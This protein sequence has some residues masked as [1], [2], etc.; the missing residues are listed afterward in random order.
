MESKLSGLARV[1]ADARVSVEE[2]REKMTGLIASAEAIQEG[3]DKDQ[4]ALTEDED[5]QVAAF[6]AAYEATKAD[7]ERRQRIAAMKDDLNAPQPRKSQT[8]PLEVSASASATP[9]ATTATRSPITGH[10]VA[11]KHPNYGFANFGKFA[12]AVRVRGLNGPEDPLLRPLGAA[13][14]W[15]SEGLGSDGGYLVPPEFS[16]NIMEKV[17]GEDSLL[18]LTDQMTTASN[19][20]TFP[21]DEVP[22]HDAVNGV[23]IAWEGEGTSYLQTKPAMRSV[24]VKLGKLAAIV[25]AS[26]EL[27]EDASSLGAYLQ[28]KIASKIVWTLNNVLVNGNGVNKPLGLLSA[29]ALVTQA[30]EGS[31]TAG[32]IN[33][34]NILKMWSRCYGPSRKRAVWI[35]NQDAEV[36][37][38]QLL[39]SGGSAVSFPAYLPN[40]MGVVGNPFSSGTLMGRPI[41]FTE[42][43]QAI[44]T[45]GDLILADMT[46]YITLSKGSG[47]QTVQSMHFFFDQGLMAYRTSYRIGGA[48]WWNSAIARAAGGN[49]NTLSCF[50]ALAAR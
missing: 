24:S 41:F 50:V 44:G 21:A 34:A 2:L 16:K 31:Q 30:A 40:Q 20:M 4:R 15:S 46:Q 5:K 39:L 23:Q 13:S 45:V 29:P 3:A 25:S 1:F 17:Q 42:A 22:S 11:E 10:T 8:P 49:T 6:F 14:T 27:L 43:A 36:Q 38:G 35:C 9:G 12:Q 28:R 18:S 47:P 48:P 26:E 37:F 7:V 32:T 33:L 19:S